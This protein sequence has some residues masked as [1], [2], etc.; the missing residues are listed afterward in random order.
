MSDPNVDEFERLLPIAQFSD[1]AVLQS[2]QPPE[3]VGGA[4]APGIMASVQCR[5]ISPQSSFALAFATRDGTRVGPFLLTPR[6][7]AEIR[8][9][10]ADSGF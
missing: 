8:K 7:A 6:V 3:T 2:A 4:W 9:A 5:L 1:R 10:L